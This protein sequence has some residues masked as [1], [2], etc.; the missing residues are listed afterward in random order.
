MCEKFYERGHDTLLILDTLV[1]WVLI[2]LICCGWYPTMCVCFF[3]KSRSVSISDSDFFLFEFHV[4]EPKP[5]IKDFGWYIIIMKTDIINIREVLILDMY[6]QH[7]ERT[8]PFP[9]RFAYLVHAKGLWYD[10][11]RLLCIT[12]PSPTSGTWQDECL[13][14]SF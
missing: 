10:I 12:R 3:F 7:G 4:V 8:T 14:S 1:V 13:K 5:L 6:H 11:L 2:S 9:K